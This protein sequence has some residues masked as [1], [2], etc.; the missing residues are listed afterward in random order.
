M[1]SNKK[2]IVYFKKN[3]K[4]GWTVDIF[5]TKK[6]TCEMVK[7]QRYCGKFS[8]EIIKTKLKVIN[9]FTLI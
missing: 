9:T 2:K 1:D 5:S 8:N 6:K 3:E 4:N 7:G